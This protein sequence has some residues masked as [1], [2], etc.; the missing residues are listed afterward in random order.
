MT[1]LERII[2]L[3]EKLYNGEP[4]ID[5]NIQETLKAISAE[6]AAHKPFPNTNSIWEITKHLIDWRAN[7][8]Q[9]LQGKIMRTPEHNYFEPIK[10]TSEVSWAKTLKAY[11]KIQNEWLTFLK[12]FDV[13]LLE[14]IYPPNQMT[15]YEHIQGVLQHD[16]YHLGQIVLLYRSVLRETK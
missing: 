13:S 8:L 7:V 1:E 16:T 4:W 9:R 14:T 5:I 11:D 15:Y 3:F 10:D 2:S 6:Q 12:Q